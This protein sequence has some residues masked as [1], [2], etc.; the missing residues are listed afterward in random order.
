MFQDGTTCGG[1]DTFGTG[2]PSGMSA[3]IRS[4]QASCLLTPPIERRWPLPAY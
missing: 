2:R 3:R 4:K 1:L